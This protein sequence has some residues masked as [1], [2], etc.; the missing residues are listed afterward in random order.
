MRPPRTAQLVAALISALSLLVLTLCTV[1]FLR[2]YRSSVIESA[3]TGSA[4]AVSQVVGTVGAYVDTLE[5]AVG[6]VKEHLGDEE[7][8]R[9]AFLAALLTARPEIAAITV[10]DEDGALLNCWAQ[11][12][13]TPSEDIV[14]NLSFD[15]T[16]AKRLGQGYISTPHVESI[17]TGYY[18]W[19][20]SVVRR[21]PDGGRRCWVSIDVSFK[22]L[23]GTISGV[24]IGRHG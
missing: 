6:I 9:D 14:R 4:Q 1:L 16:T 7:P 2:S 12:G 17:F 10:Y 22:E 5:G 18:P 21:I 11:D 3:R 20:V 23:A 24:G 19:V 13:R 15:L 8:A